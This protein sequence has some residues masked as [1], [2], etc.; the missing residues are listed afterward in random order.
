MWR[1]QVLLFLTV[2][3]VLRWE[4]SISLLGKLLFGKLLLFGPARTAGAA[5]ASQE[6]SEFPKVSR[7]WSSDRR[8]DRRMEWTVLGRKVQMVQRKKI[9]ALVLRSMSGGSYDTRLRG[10]LCYASRMSRSKALSSVQDKKKKIIEYPQARRVDT[11][12][13]VL[14]FLCEMYINA[15]TSTNDAR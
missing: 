14:P 3:Q 11:W 9:A 4:C 7:S 10:A 12:K 2:L 15:I 1:F 5:S 6:I 8:A 13:P